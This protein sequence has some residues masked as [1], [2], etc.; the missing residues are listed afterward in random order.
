MRRLLLI[1]T[2]TTGA[3]AA[4]GLLAWAE[5]VNRRA[6]RR[7]LGHLAERG[8]REAVVV[9]GY[10]DAGPRANFVNRYRVRVGLRSL[11]PSAAESVLLMCG[12]AVG[13]TVPEAEL[14]ARYARDRGHTGPILLDTESRTTAENIR[15]AIALIGAADTIRIASNAPHALV[16][17]ECLWEM[18]PDL[19]ARLARADDDRLGEAPI[20]KV[21]AAII[22]TR[23]RHRSAR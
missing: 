19:A 15:H 11:S 20:L 6:S 17:R 14:M 3:A 5:L 21:A 10:R 9:L 23:H 1:L 7:A 22:A 8:G 16:G 4:V 13:G 18:R 2:G 12:G